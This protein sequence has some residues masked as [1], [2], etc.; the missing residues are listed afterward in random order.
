VDPV[1]GAARH[2]PWTVI[3]TPPS[4]ATPRTTDVTVTG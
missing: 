4:P 3:R 1:A 2:A